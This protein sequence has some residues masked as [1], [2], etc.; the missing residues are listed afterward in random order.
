[1]KR[2]YFSILRTIS[3]AGALSL[4]AMSANAI[5]YTPAGSPDFSGYVPGQTT[6]AQIT[7]D[8][9]API[10][11]QTDAEGAPTAM[12]FRLPLQ[13]ETAATTGGIASTAK[14]VGFA[15]LKSGASSLLGHIPGLGGMAA[16]V[17]VDAGT[18]KMA[19]QIVGVGTQVWLCRVFFNHSRYSSA[20]CGLMNRP[21]GD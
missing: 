15:R 12:D 9:G 5:T 4:A 6:A 20:S 1:M 2:S 10:S 13:G 16:A 7:A 21:I 11:S 3:A 18:A 19:G 17:A 8:L 14:G